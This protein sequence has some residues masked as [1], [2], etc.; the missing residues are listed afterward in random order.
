[1][2][3]DIDAGSRDISADS[4]DVNV[5]RGDISTKHG[6]ILTKHVDD[7]SFCSVTLVLTVGNVGFSG[8]IP[9]YS[10]TITFT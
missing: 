8:S 6:D 5:E 7:V 4:R 1:M 2:H 10:I 9:C 3:G